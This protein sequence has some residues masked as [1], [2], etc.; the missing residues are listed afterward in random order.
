VLGKR[1]RRVRREAARKRPASKEWGTSLGSRPY[2]ESRP[3]RE[4]G[5]A[6]HMG[7]GTQVLMIDIRR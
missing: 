7:E 3:A 5:K 2:Q 1:A 4:D 6:V